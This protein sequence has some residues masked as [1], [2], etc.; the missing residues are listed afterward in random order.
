MA[1]LLRDGDV[2]CSLET[3]A[4]ARARAKGLLGRDGLDG[5]LLI[6]PGVQVHTFGMR[7]SIDVAYVD[8]SMRVID[9]VHR[10]RPWRLGAPRL[11]GR[12]VIEAPA[13]S[14]E[15]WSLRVGDELEIG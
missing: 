1:W 6:S 14:F 2:L 13:G 10:M 8:S 5:A 3:A 15:R 12:Y 7:F 11:R 4:T 9:V